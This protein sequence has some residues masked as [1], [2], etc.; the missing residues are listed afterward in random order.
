MNNI[1]Y[2]FCCF[3]T[4]MVIYYRKMH[5]FQDCMERHMCRSD[6]RTHLPVK[7]AVE[8]AQYR[9]PPIKKQI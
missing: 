1:N 7:R 3:K 2:A 9:K 6:S 4:F 5:L 8:Q